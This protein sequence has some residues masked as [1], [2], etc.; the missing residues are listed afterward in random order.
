[1]P[2]L[3]AMSFLSRAQETFRKK[4]R[5]EQAADQLWFHIA[6]GSNLEV[7]LHLKRDDDFIQAIEILQKRHPEVQLRMYQSRGIVLGLHKPGVTMDVSP[8]AM[9]ALKRGGN[10]GDVGQNVTVEQMLA[11]HEAWLRSRGLDPG[12]EERRAQEAD[13]ARHAISV[14]GTGTVEEPA[15]EERLIAN[16]TPTAP[17]PVIPSKESA[18]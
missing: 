8:E 12:A 15:K 10:F 14:G 7:P 1:M 13:A 9:A 16:L 11:Q 18:P 2:T 5:L 4:R 6:A 17:E 3:R